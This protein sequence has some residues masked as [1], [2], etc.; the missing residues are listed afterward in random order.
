M[1]LY[2]AKIAS[3]K[4]NKKTKKNRVFKFVTQG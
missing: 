1:I 4:K 2:F 3:D